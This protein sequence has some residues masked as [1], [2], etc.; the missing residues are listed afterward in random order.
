MLPFAHK[1]Y[2]LEALTVSLTYGWQFSG[3]RTG[4]NKSRA[5]GEWDG[6]V[7]RGWRFPGYL[8]LEGTLIHFVSSGRLM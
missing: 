6:S 4:G 1:I 3:W 5:M 7:M 2:K 8:Y